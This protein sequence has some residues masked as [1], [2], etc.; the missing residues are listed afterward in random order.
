VT[1][2]S[3]RTPFSLL[4][5]LSQAIPD[6]Q[7]W[8]ELVDRYGRQIHA[9][10]RRWGL[11]EA[12]AQDVTQ[13]VLLQLASKLQTFTYDPGAALPGWTLTHH[14]GSDFL[15]SWRRPARGSGGCSTRCRPATS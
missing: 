10:C 4:L 8:A 6:Q 7:V 15:A 13:T 9:W 14:A 2:S 1:E 12:D 11:K 3:L 5:R